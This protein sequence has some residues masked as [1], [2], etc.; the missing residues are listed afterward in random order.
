MQV[1]LVD[2]DHLASNPVIL[3]CIGA[4][5]LLGHFRKGS[6]L[7]RVG[8]RLVIGEPI[9]QVATRVTPASRI[10]TSMRRSQEHQ[11]RL[12]VM[13]VRVFQPSAFTLAAGMPVETTVI[14]TKETP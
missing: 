6:L 4:G 2:S 13:D 5:I 12:S 11:T 3:S 7:V 1:L 10:S 14:L 9:A 8:R